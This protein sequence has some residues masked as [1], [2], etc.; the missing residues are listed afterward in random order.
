MENQGQR[1]LQRLRLKQHLETATARPEQE[2]RVNS[3]TQRE[4]VV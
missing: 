3:F 1:Q 2:S 4:R